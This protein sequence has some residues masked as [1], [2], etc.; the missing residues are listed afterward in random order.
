ML[1]RSLI[2]ETDSVPNLQLALGIELAVLPPYLYACWSI[3]PPS[4]GGSE[5]A[6][7]ASRTIR[8]VL[9][10]EM[11]HLAVAANILNALGK[12]PRFTAQL[13][14]YPG[15]LPGHVQTGK[16]AFAVG[17]C[18]LSRATI[19]TFMKIELP[20]WDADLTASDDWITLGA[21]YD[22]VK[23]QL[24]ALPAG[25]FRHG[26]QLPARDNPAPG[27]LQPV[28]DFGSA[29]LAIDSI[30]AQGEGHRPKKGQPPTDDYMS[31]DAR[32]VAHFYKFKTIGSCFDGGDT[33]G[34]P[35]IDPDRDLFAVIDNPDAAMFS[36][37][38]KQMNLRFN[39]RY[40]QLLDTLELRLAGPSPEVFGA[41]TKLMAGLEHD[42]AVL[43]N[44]GTVPG[45]RFVAGPT[46]EYIGAGLT[47]AA[48]RHSSPGA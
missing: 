5:A 29:K 41:A 33:P 19:D 1:R 35:L 9:Y 44:A 6:A 10:Q 3:K 17:L 14:K 7:E 31:D 43:R 45:T 30:I 23:V 37:V 25:A 40:S 20:E 18:R 4:A 39:Q 36:E 27:N 42:A 32:E 8:S 47:A 22:K 13:M 11:L 26:R 38:Q 16:F 34:P 24:E 46:F 15:S 21:F 2:S 48:A 12:P 28:N